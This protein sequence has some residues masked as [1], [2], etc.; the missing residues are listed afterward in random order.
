[1]F[2]ESEFLIFALI[3][4]RIWRRGL[5]PTTWKQ[6]TAGQ[7]VWR[8]QPHNHCYLPPQCST[9][10]PSLGWHHQSTVRFRGSQGGPPISPTYGFVSWTSLWITPLSSI[11]RALDLIHSVTNLICSS[12]MIKWMQDTSSPRSTSTSSLRLLLP[13]RHLERISGCSNT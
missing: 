7:D 12:C 8:P 11:I 2:T 5:W 3:V 9:G 1:M 4:E 13:G 10:R 6:N